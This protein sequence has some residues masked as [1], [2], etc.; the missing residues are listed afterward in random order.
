MHRLRPL[1]G[2]I[3]A[4]SDLRKGLVRRGFV[5]PRSVLDMHIRAGGVMRFT[6]LLISFGMLCLVVGC[7]DESSTSIGGAGTADMNRMIGADASEQADVLSLSSDV[8]VG[9]TD[10]LPSREDA[11]AVSCTPNE[12]TG[13]LDLRNQR[14]CDPTGTRFVAG[15]CPEGERCDDGECVPSFCVQGELVCLDG[16]TVGECRRDETGFSP[17]RTCVEGSP[18]VE[19]RCESACNPA[20]K[21]PS[22]IG[23]EYWSVDLDNY[24]DEFSGFP[25]AVPH[26][27]VISNTSDLPAMVTVEGPQG[28]PLTNPQFTVAAGDLSVFTFPR[29]DVDGTGIFDRAFKINST[30]PVIVYQF[31]P[32]NNEGVASNDASLLL[33]KEGLG[34]DY[35]G[36][37]GQRA[38]C[39]VSTRTIVYHL[40]VDT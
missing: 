32:L 7:E 29:L 34:R 31:N 16:T 17:V 22:N 36:V 24:P 37:T 38:P 23:C 19:G 27:V 10:M 6:I 20:G 14:I 2:P 18:C 4:I 1:C 30:Q 39:H 11:S 3:A 40:R 15:E 5:S 8:G 21:V 26:A 12:I 25:D 35:V 33:P 13:C 28:V 9:M